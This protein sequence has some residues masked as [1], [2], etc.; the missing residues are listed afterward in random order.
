ME[1]EQTEQTGIGDS[2]EEDSIEYIDEATPGPGSYQIT[3]NITRKRPHTKVESFGT[4]MQRF[5]IPTNTYS[6][7]PYLQPHYPN[8]KTSSQASSKEVGFGTTTKPPKE[9]VALCD[10]FYD[11]GRS[12]EH[13]SYKAL[14]K[15]Q[16]GDVGFNSTKERFE[17]VKKPKNRLFEND[18]E[19]G[20]DSESDWKEEAQRPTGIFLS[21]VSREQWINTNT[22]NVDFGG[23]NYKC[24]A[25]TL[26]KDK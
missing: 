9:S 5:K 3:T 24:M 13:Q 14:E 23:Q 10:K 19:S 2:F 12:L 7:T 20:S 16:K 6:M 25:Q 15:S 18:E 22:E 17:M 26:K 11:D 1:K 8:F 4:T 21:K